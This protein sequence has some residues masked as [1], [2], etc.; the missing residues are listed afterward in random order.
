MSPR[1][2]HSA[3]DYLQPQ[4]LAQVQGVELRARHIVEG[5]MTGMH[6]SPHFG[7]SVEFAQHR[8]YTSGDDLRHLDWKVFGRTDKLYLKQYQQ[9][10]NL[11]LMLLVDAS[12]SMSYGTTFGTSK[13]VWRKFDHATA[14]AAALSYIALQQ[15]DRAG[16]IVFADR[17]M[18]FVRPSN[19]RGQWRSIVKA[20]STHPVE[21][22]TQMGRVFDEVLGK[23]THRTL[24][25]VLSDLFEESSALG[26]ALARL[27]HRRHDVMLM[28]TL[29]K[30][31]LTFPFVNPQRLLGLENEGKI[32]LD[33]KALREAY[34]QELN[35]HI[36]AIQSEARK[37]RYDHVLIDTT[38]EV[39][40]PLSHFLAKRTAR[41][42]RA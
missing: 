18:E 28:Q 3:T 32:D 9:E 13:N 15:Q 42:K 30:A 41:L 20:L 8:P 26:A 22:P 31:E 25:V 23:L 19:A 21:Q 11:D 24:I 35:A 17:M 5:L 1:P 12:G 33:P 10:T 2:Q 36:R 6:R 37:Y 40:P 16:L 38:S 4:T 29:D 34:L 27:H 39:G 7:Y 14:I